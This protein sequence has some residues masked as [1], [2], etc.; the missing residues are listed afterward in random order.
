MKQTIH[1]YPLR[2]AG[3]LLSLLAIV[4]LA[5]CS[6]FE[7]N[8][9]SDSTANRLNQA[10]AQYIDI[11]EGKEAGWVLDFY[12]ADRSMG[13]IAY[14]A[15]FH[16]GA[17]TM[18]CEMDMKDVDN[19]SLPAGS[20]A[21]SRYRVKTERSVLLTF[22]TFN[23]LLHYW[24][25]PSG[26]DS[27]GY[28]SDYEFVFI[29]A[30]PD[31]VILQ[32]KKYGNLLKM[33]PLEGS[34]SDYTKQVAA[35]KKSLSAVPRQRAVIDG[36]SVPVSML[37]SH[38]NYTGADGKACHVPFVYTPDGLRFYQTVTLSGIPFREMTVGDDGQLLAADGKIEL[39]VP[40]LLERFTG[41]MTQWHFIYSTTNRNRC[42]MC[43]EFYYILMESISQCMMEAW[44]SVGDMYVGT[45]KIPAS[46]DAHRTVIG[47]STTLLSFGYEVAYAID[48]KVVSEE[49]SLVSITPT[50]GATL[51][52][53]YSF[54]QPLVDFIGNNSPYVLSFN[55]QDNPTLVT[56]T[57][58]KDSDLWFNLRLR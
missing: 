18:T 54:F 48:M 41:S 47:W 39:P 7:D 22:D 5:S 29:S 17:V 8:V 32:G 25:T 19:R 57:S 21:E 1:T 49:E 36:K 16:D 40:T 2:Q 46:E 35:T 28:A 11:L 43:D 51:F 56:L 44:E 20:E 13:G 3:S 55:N 33:Y 27:D 52:Y 15:R 9:F 6:R 34:A 38:L 58:Q 12:P 10:T 4:L 30:S 45:S 53:N 26:N 42:Q 24:S 23:P 50:E 31:S 14:T 37:D